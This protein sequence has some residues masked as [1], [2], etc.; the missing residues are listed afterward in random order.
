MKVL[1]VSKA[2]IEWFEAIKQL[3]HSQVGSFSFVIAL[4][5]IKWI[6]LKFIKCWHNQANK[7]LEIK[8]ERQDQKASVQQKLALPVRS[9]PWWLLTGKLARKLE[10]C[11]CSNAGNSDRCGESRFLCRSLYMWP[12]MK[13]WGRLDMCFNSN[14]AVK[15]FCG[16]DCIDCMG[17]GKVPAVKICAGN[18]SAGK[19]PCTV[20]HQ[21]LVPL[22]RNKPINANWPFHT[23][24]KLINPNHPKTC[25]HPTPSPIQL[26]LPLP[27]LQPTTSKPGQN[28]RGWDPPPPG[29]TKSQQKQNLHPRIHSFP[30]GKEIEKTHNEP[31][32]ANIS[33]CFPYPSQLCPN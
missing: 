4:K 5:F 1:S 29:P 11:F 15:E 24:Y 18:K 33:I 3:C 22:A 10:L 21:L 19:D 8:L 30:F 23:K 27:H 2:E 7:G 14:Y 28:L 31:T 20:S 32:T 26:Q 12:L 16:E 13:V 6:A 25:E 17:T 9:H